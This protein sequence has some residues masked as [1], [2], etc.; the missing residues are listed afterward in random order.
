MTERDYCGEALAS[1]SRDNDT[2][3]TTATPGDYGDA[4]WL[5]PDVQLVHD[6]RT[7]APALDEDAL[8]E[9]WESW[10]VTEAAA[11]GCPH[12]YVAAGLIGA[13]SGWIGNA[14]RIQ[15]T[16]DWTEPPQLWTALIGAPSAGKTPALRPV[17]E[18][19]GVLERDAEPAWR[20]ALAQHERDA[21]AA[22]AI[23]EKW[24]A[25]VHAAVKRGT[26]P[27][28]RPFRAQAP[29]APTM[30]RVMS[31]DASTEALQRLLAENARGLLHVR[32]ELAG[33]L[34]SFDRYGGKGADRAFYLETWNG[35]DY[36]CDR[37][38]YNSAPVRIKRASLAIVGGMVPDRLR[39]ALVDVDDG[40]AAR[41]VYVWPEL[42]K[43]APLVNSR[44]A[45]AAER[46]KR[47]MTAAR[48]LRALP[49]DSD[50]RGEPAPRALRLDADAL[51]LFGELRG[52]AME[53]A[54][55][56]SGLAAGWHGKTPGRALRVALVYGMLTR[57]AAGGGESASVSADAMARAGRYLD[58]A[59]AMLDRVLGQLAISRAEADAAMIAR[60]VLASC[61]RR[62][63][64]RELYQTP[65]FTWARDAVRRNAALATLNQA[66]WI[67][68]GNVAGPGRP[69]GDW[70]VSPH[71]AADF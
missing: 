46:R 26:T 58:Y 45:E 59:A 34:G 41:F 17:I 40:L 22:H 9:G 8:P 35:G 24:R 54:R 5:E 56:A 65:G 2:P 43:I 13:A 6:D 31:M 69:R 39:E 37:V 3:G 47:L 15:A 38:K 4:P 18:T 52:K 67:R 32:D 30:P 60:H 48:L 14:R 70:D 25:D 16:A 33:W 66:G 55:T 28:D 68:H 64:E 19:S 50:D 49:M 36:V 1:A 10:V 51:Q 27:P 62:L 29:T 63:N 53:Q 11:R 7:P 57:A 12:D 42:V 21:Q 20:D 71:L 61:G 44:D 23:E